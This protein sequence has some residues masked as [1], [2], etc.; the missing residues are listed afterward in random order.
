M[1]SPLVDLILK[2]FNGVVF[3]TD[4]EDKIIQCFGLIEEILSR[5]EL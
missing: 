5:K 3:V 1:L 4:E 2:A